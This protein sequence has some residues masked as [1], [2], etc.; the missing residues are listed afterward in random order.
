VGEQFDRWV[1]VVHD[2]SGR[3]WTVEVHWPKLTR[4]A[5]PLVVR[6]MA[7]VVKYRE[8]VQPD[9]DMIA[10]RGVV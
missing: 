3:Q 2:P 7:G 1:E 4:A 5:A 10:P 8:T 6:S 9:E